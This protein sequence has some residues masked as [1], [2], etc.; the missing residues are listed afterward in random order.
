M[1]KELKNIPSSGKEYWRSLEQRVKAPETEAFPHRE[2]PEGT[3]EHGATFSRRNFLSLMGASLALAGLT[4][5]RRPV[6]KIIPYVIAPEEIIPGIPLYYATTMPFGTEAIGLV[7]ENHEGRPT[8]LEGNPK[9]PQS[10]GKANVFAQAAILDLYD[11]D[12]SQSVLYR[13]EERSWSEFL[14]AWKELIKEY[15]SSDGEGLAILSEPFASPT[16]ARLK[17]AFLR[18]FPK[19]RWAA[20]EPVN[21][22]NIFSGVNMA[23]GE[24]GRPVYHCTEA[25]V[26]LALDSDFLQLEHD[27]IRNAAGFA[28][29]RRVIT[30]DDEMN[31]LYVVESA[32]TVTGGMADHRYRLQSRQIGAFTA[33]LALE[34]TTRGLPVDGVESLD[35]YKNHPF[36]EKWLGAL[37]DDLI[38]NT[39]RS[40]VVAGRRQPAEV[41]ALVLAINSAL[42]NI[43]RTVEYYPIG[44]TEA[45]RQED[46]VSLVQAADS[47]DVTA[48]VILGGN[49]VYNTPVDLAFREAL[50]KITHTVHLSTHVDET[51]GYVEWHIPEAHFL[52]CWGDVQTPDG[53]LSIVQPQIEPLFG[54]KSKAEV[55]AAVSTGDDRSGYDLVRETWQS[56]L[57]GTDF[58]RQWR[59]ILHDGVYD[60]SKVKPS[61]VEIRSQKLATVLDR[62]PFPTDSATLNSMEIVYQVSNSVYDGRFANNGWLQELPDPVTKLTWDNAIVMSRRTAQELGVKNEDLVTLQH[63]GRTLQL[64]VWILPGHADY[65][66]SV[67][68]GYGREAV[69]RIGN[70]VG[71]NV[72]TLRRSNAP[73]FDIGVSIQSTGKNYLL[74]CTQ[75]HHGLDVEKLARESIRDRLPIIVREATLEEYRENGEFVHEIVEPPPKVSMWKEIKYDER[76]QWG[77]TIDLNVCTGCNAC[78]IACQSENNIP[79]VGKEEV[80][81]GREMHW[82]RL[83]RYYSGDPD[84]PEMVHQPVS[85]QQCEMA[86]CEQVCPVAATTHTKDGLNGMTY[87]RCVGTRYCANNCPYKV[88]RFNFYNYAKGWPEIV[89]MVRNP[90]VTVRFRGVMEKC[91]YCVQRIALGKIAAKKENRE[92]RDGEVVSACQQTC[93]TDAI[94]FGDILDPNSKIFKVKQQNRRYELLEELNIRPRTSF[95][96][97]LRNPNPDL[98]QTQNPKD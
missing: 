45:A 65:S 34:L 67:E 98:K 81:L 73:G 77:M 82:M 89:Q 72:Y 71:G 74:A 95:L 13:G 70:G 68:L 64:P 56:I 50:E 69:G 21:D 38:K 86:P 36:D 85:C 15:E 16:L 42:K 4:S 6:E 5:C 3:A 59:R 35:A 22:E 20:Y 75:D 23:I 10:L 49:P 39:G 29:G 54:G 27:N 19:A 88:R 28:D 84:D 53:V 47:G 66:I 93:P 90:D 7:V 24:I 14:A 1:S 40:L 55:L 48:L 11:P 37:A 60:G 17:K 97:K 33:A 46:L 2:F 8:K 52:E 78:T 80:R 18:R 9:H 76:P 91:T 26:I 25:R 92:I 63:R 62:K 44:D 51:S 43:N 83:D 32:M 30:R 57:T 79:V 31:R 61:R 94:V 58:N 87:N 41:H 12:R 96:A